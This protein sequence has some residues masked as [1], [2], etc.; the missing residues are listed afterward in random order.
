MSASASTP[1]VFTIEIHNQAKPV[2]PKTAKPVQPAVTAAS[3][4][5]TRKPTKITTTVTGNIV[6]ATPATPVAAKKPPSKNQMKCLLALQ[7]S[8]NQGS[9]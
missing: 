5:I 6:T 7:A 3:L 4:E 8:L 1:K 2:K 9:K